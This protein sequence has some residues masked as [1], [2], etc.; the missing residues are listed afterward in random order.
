MREYLLSQW[1]M[2]TVI[3]LR[4]KLRPMQPLGTSGRNGVNAVPAATA[5]VKL[6]GVIVKRMDAHTGAREHRSEHATLKTVV[7]KAC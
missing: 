3:L 2:A 4:T 6:D 1:R 7:A 5:V